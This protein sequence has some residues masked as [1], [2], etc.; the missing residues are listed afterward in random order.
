MEIEDRFV[1]LVTSGEVEQLLGV[2]PLQHSTG[3][4]H[5]LVIY[6]TLIDCNLEQKIIGLCSDITATNLGH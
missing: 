2:P 3:K 5:F 4:E 6:E 1:V